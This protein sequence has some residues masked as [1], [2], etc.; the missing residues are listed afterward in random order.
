MKN[1]PAE[2]VIAA[3]KNPVMTPTELME[4]RKVLK[5][6]HSIA[7][8]AGHV[9]K[10]I[11]TLKR[12]DIIDMMLDSILMSDIETVMPV[13]RIDLNMFTV[14]EIQTLL[15]NF[16]ASKALMSGESTMEIDFQMAEDIVKSEVVED[17]PT[18][19]VQAP[20]AEDD[21]VEKLLEIMKRDF[22]AQIPA[23]IGA[24]REATKS[25]KPDGLLWLEVAKLLEGKHRHIPIWN[26]RLR[27]TLIEDGVVSAFCQV[28][29][30]LKDWR[31]ID[32]AI[33]L[34]NAVESSLT[35]VAQAKYAETE[36]RIKNALENGPS[37][38]KFYAEKPLTVDLVKAYLGIPFEKKAQ[39]NDLMK[40]ITTITSFCAPSKRAAISKRKEYVEMGY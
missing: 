18:P 2:E 5:E 15:P 8:H 35:D 16:D 26:S 23:A 1:T 20:A 25:T 27:H 12:V 30:H 13:L 9:K 28:K 3:P 7:V 33:L 22:I 36:M 32:V 29:K 19:G 24:F 39:A 14:K 10:A 34:Q 11:A 40:A 38:V 37:L 31:D 6:K 17:E 21:I 4:L